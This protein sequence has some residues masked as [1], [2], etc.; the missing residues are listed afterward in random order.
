MPILP[1]IDLLILTGWTSLFMAF[2]LKAIYLT[3]HYRPLF[4]G[5]TPMDLVVSS[6]VMLLFAL[7]LA[8]R[9]WVKSH[10]GD[11]IAASRRAA[12]GFDRR[13]PSELREHRPAEMAEGEEGDEQSVA[14]RRSMQA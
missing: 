1:I 14:R 13:Q 9:T 3:T 10:E 12:A 7:A 5:L 6:G 11:L 8:A 2:A 4:F